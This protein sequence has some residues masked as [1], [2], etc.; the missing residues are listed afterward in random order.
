ML[1]GREPYQPSFADEEAVG[2][3]GVHHPLGGI[4]DFFQVPIIDLNKRS[5]RSIGVLPVG[6]DV[7][8]RWGYDRR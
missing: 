6:M 2:K 4:G 1:I 3:G 8:G 5:P 7:L